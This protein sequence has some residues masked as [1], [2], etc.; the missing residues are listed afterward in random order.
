MRNRQEG[1]QGNILFLSQ[2]IQGHGGFWVCRTRARTETPYF[3]DFQL[4]PLLLGQWDQMSLVTKGSLKYE[5]M[6]RR[7]IH[8][9]KNWNF[10]KDSLSVIR[11]YLKLVL[12]S[13][14]LFR[15]SICLWMK[16]SEKQKSRKSWEV[17]MH[18]KQREV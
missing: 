15:P 14:R 1:K 7:G 16:V 5:R 4:N 6:L 18:C 10:L 17:W 9:W 12:H 3:T 2:G 11:S 8:G 13:R